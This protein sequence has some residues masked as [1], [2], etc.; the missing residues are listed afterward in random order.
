MVIAAR[1]DA[2]LRNALEIFQD[3][4]MLEHLDDLIAIKFEKT[5]KITQGAGEFT[6]VTYKGVHKYQ[7]TDQNKKMRTS[8]TSNDEEQT[9]ALAETSEHLRAFFDSMTIESVDP[10]V[11]PR[12][13][14]MQEIA[15]TWVAIKAKIR[16]NS[17]P[18]RPR[19][20]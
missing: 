10:E 7:K 14:S 11:P 17:E 18:R 16:E 12:S 8:W 19:S 2:A 20:S 4:F 9:N 5:F 13:T 15:N 6:G 1:K 3:T